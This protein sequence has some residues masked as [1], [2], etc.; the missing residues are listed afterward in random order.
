MGEA[1]PLRA[2]LSILIKV[3]KASGES[4]PYGEVSVALVEEIFQ[5]SVGVVPLEV[6]V[7]NNQDVLVDLADGMAITEIAMAIHRE[8]QYRNQNI[9]VGCMMSGRENLISAERERIETRMQRE[10]LAREKQVFQE[11]QEEVR[12]EEQELM[13][14]Q[15]ESKLTV[16]EE[17]LRMK[18]EYTNY[19]L[20]INYLTARVQEQLSLLETVRKEIEGE[21]QKK[22]RRSRVGVYRQQN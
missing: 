22:R 8:H 15:R 21:E 9:R 6:L 2:P 20:Q 7:L 10:E 12:R 18:N 19:Q 17:S 1:D 16:Q 14:R 11:R 5:N 4:L 13:D 3:T